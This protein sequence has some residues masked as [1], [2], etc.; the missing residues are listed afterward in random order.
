MLAEVG[1]KVD[2]LDCFKSEC[3][4]IINNEITKFQNEEAKKAR[5]KS[6]GRR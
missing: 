5:L 1:A 3:F 4:A 2:S 6:H